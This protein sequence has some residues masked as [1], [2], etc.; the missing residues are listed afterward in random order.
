MVASQCVLD[1]PYRTLSMSGKLN[2]SACGLMLR[3][4]RADDPIA[5]GAKIARASKEEKLAYCSGAIN[6]FNRSRRY[7]K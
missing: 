1:C 7:R 5:E 4:T 3:I 2:T 6:Q